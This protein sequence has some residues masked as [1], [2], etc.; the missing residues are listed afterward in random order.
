MMCNVLLLLL[1]VSVVR[2]LLGV[3]P[4]G[5]PATSDS[6]KNQNLEEPII[7][8]GSRFRR[9]TPTHADTAPAPAAPSPAETMYTSAMSPLPW[10]ESLN[11]TRDLTYMP[12][13]TKTLSVLREMGASEIPLESSIAQKRSD[14]KPARIG[15]MEFQTE[16]FRKIRMTYFDA[17]DAVQVFNAVFYPAYEYDLP[18]LGFD[19][20]SLGRCLFIYIPYAKD[21][22][23]TFILTYAGFTYMAYGIR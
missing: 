17:G 16:Q 20:I 4:R 3:Q 7:G 15:N 2:A 22:I 9:P 18:I 23:W 11:P 12:M 5:F 19:L 6:L 13:F 8:L 14:V 1:Q 10:S 21:Q